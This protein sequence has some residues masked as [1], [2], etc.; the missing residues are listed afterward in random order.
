[1][2]AIPATVELISIIERNAESKSLD[3]KGPMTW[4]ARD[5]RKCCELVKDILAFANTEGG[6]IVIGVADADHGFQLIGVTPDQAGT[7][8]SSAICQFV[9]NYTDPPINLRAKKVSHKGNIFV[10]LEV[11]RFT[12][13][14]HICQKDYPDVLN[15]RTVYVRTDNN[16][17][18][19]IKSSADFRALIENAI[20]NRKDALLSSFRAILVGSIAET[21][22]NPS[23]EEKFQ[24]QIDSA[25]KRF[26]EKYP[27]KGKGYTLFYETIFQPETFDQ[28]RFKAAKLTRAA[29]GACV[30]FTGWPFLFIHYNRPDCLITSD[31]GLEGEV[32]WQD[33]A[34][35]DAYD[36]WRLNESGLF[37][38]KELTAMSGSDPATAYAEDIV[39]LCAEAI[40]TLTRLYEDLLSDSEMMRLQITLFGTRNRKLVWSDRSLPMRFLHS[41]HV[42]NRPSLQVKVAYPLA[43]WRAGIVD[44]AISLA[45]Q[46]LNGFGL[47]N[48]NEVQMKTQI[49]N[50]LGRRF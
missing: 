45:K 13:T 5:K 50:L 48:P 33:F 39:R 6:H 19:P 43:E 14:P 15:D 35:H 9:Q 30:S 34:K 7:Y 11:P 44:H 1:V 41:G 3:Y 40:H 10:V 27:Y 20:R 49:D 29:E 16:E 28:Y 36:F 12:D 8:D 46:F 21:S 18:A 38:K 17:S 4:D 22:Q 26:D 32:T 31:E 25:R 47:E 42:A 2:E 23:D 24:E 37:Y